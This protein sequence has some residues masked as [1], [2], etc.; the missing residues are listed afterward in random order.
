MRPILFNTEM[1][2]AILD[3]HK[4][5]MRRVVKLKYDNTHL[6]MRTDKYGV[7]LIEL[8]NKE[9]GA[10]TIKNPDGTTTHKLLA[11][12]ERTPHYHPGDILYVRETW[13]K[14]YDG[15]YIYRA[16][17][18]IA[19]L[20]SFQDFS[21]IIY[22]PS[23]HMPLDAAR[24]FLRV[25]EVR[26]ERLQ[27]ITEEQAKAEGARAAYPFKSYID[28]FVPLWNGAIKTKDR[29]L[30]GWDA[31]PWVWVIEFERISKEEA[32]K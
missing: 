7:R 15:G 31:N 29:D 25:K 20:P 22:Y 16:N 6:E 26:V 8:Q 30:Y 23:I 24:I 19:D 1:V 17:N 4:T 13:A 28:G 11:A 9:P 32:G 14:G 27:D 21:K 5:V 12:I 10:T 3:G 18:R 2:R